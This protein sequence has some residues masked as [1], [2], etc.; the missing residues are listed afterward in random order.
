[1]HKEKD[2]KDSK[3]ELA[4]SY[5][6]NWDDIYQYKPSDELIEH[7]K[8]NRPI[9]K[10]FNNPDWQKTKEEFGFIFTKKL[11]EALDNATFS[12]NYLFKLL[13]QNDFLLKWLID[14]I[15]KMSIVSVNKKR[16]IEVN[17]KWKFGEA[18]NYNISPDLLFA[19]KEQ[20]VTWDF[21]SE[22]QKWDSVIFKLDKENKKDKENKE[23]IK[24]LDDDE[25]FQE[26]IVCLKDRKEKNQKKKQIDFIISLMVEQKNH[27][28]DYL[29]DFSEWLDKKFDEN[30]LVDVYQ[31]YLK[32]LNSI[33]KT[34]VDTKG[35]KNFA[36]NIKTKKQE[37]KEKVFN[38]LKNVFGDKLFF[39]KWSDIDK[40]ASLF[41]LKLA[42]FVSP[43]PYSLLKRAWIINELD[44]W[45]YEADWLFIDVGWTVNWLKI[46]ENKLTIDEH[47]DW[48]IDAKFAKRPTS[49]THMIYNIL[50]K[51]WSF[52]HK[53]IPQID[54]FVSFVDMVDSMDYQING[55]DYT[56]SYKTFFGLYGNLKIE[57]IY[58]Y[59]E[60]PK[61]TGLE[62]LDESFLKKH[63]AQTVYGP[64]KSTKN[65][66]LKDA[67]EELKSK[68]DEN[69]SKFE[70]LKSEWKILEFKGQKYIVD[71]ENV[72][73][74][75]D[76][77]KVSQYNGFW[78]FKIYQNWDLYIYSPKKFPHKVAWFVPNDDH[79]LII[80]W[81]QKDQI[82][83]ILQEFAFSEAVINGLIENYFVKPE[84]VSVPKFNKINAFSN[85]DFSDLPELSIDKLK[86]K[87]RSYD[88]VINNIQGKLIFVTFDRENKV[89]WIFHRDQIEKEIFDSI[90][91]WDKISVKIDSIERGEKPKINVIF[92]SVVEESHSKQKVA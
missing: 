4:Y 14:G 73:K 82:N 83:N 84:I 24:K 28:D 55:I 77:P 20:N 22:F 52:D 74:G 76:G 49:S 63:S 29:Q 13:N 23:K 1:M 60:D 42:K 18:G 7:L 36:E 62:F 56:N 78:L 61:H 11:Q 2:K 71:F 70:K 10:E 67:S 45:N 5:K 48:S 50:K 47:S 68:I 65:K 39:H 81:I 59:F 21:W 79:F 89:N 40:S 25:L 43:E 6:L 72:F 54:R 26:L 87:E 3:A 27:N 8:G 85:I 34:N 35:S 30:G 80:K 53:S 19:C 38:E 88:V 44:Y 37:I 17:I 64:N 15:Y 32:S 91:K 51:L 16:W 69:L 66:T 9:L 86:E 31:D 58:N 57:D 90:K 41:L 92:N 12:N 75:R 46:Q 33:W